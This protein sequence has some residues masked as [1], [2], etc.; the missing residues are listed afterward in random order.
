MTLTTPF[1]RFDDYHITTQCFQVLSLYLMLL[2][3]QKGSRV[4]LPVA[5]GLGVLSGLATVNRLNDGAALGV[6]CGLAL[7]VLARP[8]RLAA[9]TVLIVCTAATVL[10]VVAITGDPVPVW[11][12]ETVTHASR[13]KGGTG[14]ILL[15]PLIF[16]LRIAVAAL[17]PKGL[18][19]I[20]LVLGSFALFAKNSRAFAKGHRLRSAT[21]WLLLGYLVAVLA[22]F[23]WQGTHNLA[24]AKLG[25]FGV[26]FGVALG[27]WA[28][29]SIVTASVRSEKSTRHPLQVLLLIPFWALLAAAMTSGA[30]FPDYESPVA[31]LLVLV[32]I[33]LPWGI[34][35]A[36]QRRGWLVL[37]AMI[38]FAAIP[39]KVLVPYDW[40][41]YHSGRLFKD[42]VWY[43]HPNY[44]P[45]LIERAQLDF[46]LPLCAQVQA[47][48]PG[49]QLLSLPYPYA[50]YFC[51]VS[52]WQGYV[53]TWYD[54]SSREQIQGLATKLADA[55]PQWISYQ[56]GLDTMALHELSYSGGRALAQRDLDTQ[57]MQ[58]VAARRWT[59]VQ[60]SCF[61]G[62][63]WLLLRSTPPHPRR[64]PA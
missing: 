4:T 47:S 13:I 6:A 22:L 42:R 16:P 60:R 56:R 15:L 45:M 8:R 39:A 63:D 58:F 37:A 19:L 57:M 64:A 49:T 29:W 28:H 9:L 36:W 27:L 11:W 2:L 62:S 35:T 12:A 40:H 51:H 53:Q 33:A 34:P 32:P 1:Y 23:F 20:A 52:P 31:L 5:A 59:I 18:T 38:V 3:W 61:G 17:Q 50:N 7:L 14:G 44:G 48:G 25:Q 55:P 41:H 10:G 21:D 26:L 46:M 43:R 30:H 54:T 24:N